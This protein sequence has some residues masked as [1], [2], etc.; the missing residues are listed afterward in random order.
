MLDDEI[1]SLLER[2]TQAGRD[3]DVTA[4]GT[5]TTATSPCSALSASCV[6]PASAIR[7]AHRVN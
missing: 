3:G 6:S 1:Q 2:L 4:L 5:L 7:T